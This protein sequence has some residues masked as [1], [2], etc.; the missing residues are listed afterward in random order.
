VLA[1][2]GLVAFPT[3]TVYG[4]GADATR[5]DAVRRI[6][7]VKR[8]PMDRPLTVH[9]APDAEVDR[10]GR[11]DDRARRLAQAFWPGPLT[12]VVPRTARVPDAVTAG[13][14]TVGLRVPDHPQ[15]IALLRAFGGGVAAP[16]ANRSGAVSPTTADH[17]RADLGDEVDFVLDAGACP[18]GMESTVVSLVDR[19]RLLR[20]GAIGRAEIAAVLS[21]EVEAP[22]SVSQGLSLRTPA[23]LRTPSELATG[24]PSL[25]PE[26]VVLTRGA[27]AWISGVGC[28]VLPLADDPVQY[29]RALYPTLREVDCA[30]H[31]VVVIEAVPEHPTWDA[32]RDRLRRI[33]TTN[34][35]DT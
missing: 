5:S 18:G 13:G 8:R 26:A 9:L 35:T 28:T 30:G 31:S 4:L 29:A 34:S 27:P 1:T 33:A 2:G 25:P 12:L 22:R 11:M 16:S 14:Q 24:A 7:A 32:V 10:W 20:F 23:V 21:E 17:V 3:E 19:A 6:F 15:A